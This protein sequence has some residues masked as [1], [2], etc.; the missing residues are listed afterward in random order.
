MEKL[1]TDWLS[2]E[3][4][5]LSQETEVKLKVVIATELYLLLYT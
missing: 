3:G 2:L 5:C 4:S 1:K